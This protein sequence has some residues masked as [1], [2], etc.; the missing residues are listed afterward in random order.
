MTADKAPRNCNH[1]WHRLG[2][3]DDCPICSP[4][5]PQR[6]NILSYMS[7][8]EEIHAIIGPLTG[9]AVN[10]IEASAYD[11]LAAERDELKERLDVFRNREYEAKNTD[12]LKAELSRE[13]KKVEKAFKDLDDLLIYVDGNA[14]ELGSR[15]HTIRNTIRFMMIQLQALDKESEGA[16]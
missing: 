8:T 3:I 9:G 7:G 5:A 16:G 4:Q 13:K 12:E 6:W 15:Y 2:G 1:S 14:D 11:A 10:V